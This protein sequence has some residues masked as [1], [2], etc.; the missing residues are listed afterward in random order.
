MARLTSSASAR[1][2]SS[3]LLRFR[4]SVTHGPIIAGSLECPRRLEGDW[5]SR[6][7]LSK[8][9]G[10][11]TTQLL[12]AKPRRPARTVGSLLRVVTWRDDYRLCLR[13]AASVVA[14]LPVPGDCLRAGPSDPFEISR[15]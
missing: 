6:D 12:R 3:K 9:N 5:A 14:S 13:A 15:V 1:A 4:I 8:R 7:A 10:S 2:T 11:L